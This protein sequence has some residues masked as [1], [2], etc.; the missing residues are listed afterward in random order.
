MKF[1]LTTASLIMVF[2][3]AGLRADGTK[4]SAPAAMDKSKSVTASAPAR[5]ASAPAETASAPA[6]AGKPRRVSASEPA[7]K[8]AQDYAPAQDLLLSAMGLI[9]VKYKWGGN[10]PESGLDCSGFV[11]YVFQNSLNIVLPRTS[12][13]MSRIGDTIEKEELKPGDLVFFNTLKRQFSHVGIYLGDNRFIHSPRKG[14]T[15]EVANM[16]DNYWTKRFNGARR[17]S[18]LD[19]E[20]LDLDALLQG[21]PAR[22]PSASAAEGRTCRKI[23]RVRNGKKIVT[24]VC[25]RK[26]ASKPTARNGKASAVASKPTAKK[27]AKKVVK[28]NKKKRG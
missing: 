15:V 22:Q 24:N 19:H 8:I 3:M 7:R 11:R 26:G 9:G 21:R 23:T 25:A 20:T 14:R 5:K 17:M 16:S 13:N 28:K 2:A 6:A 10:T 1:H 18:E 27:T 4:A 12:F